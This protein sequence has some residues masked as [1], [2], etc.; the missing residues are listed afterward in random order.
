MSP[1]LEVVEDELNVLRVNALQ[2]GRQ[3]T[4]FFCPIPPTWIWL[5]RR[6]THLST[7]QALEVPTRIL[8][9]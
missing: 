1:T 3:A 5:P 7:F 4:T 9:V 8:R 2:F 6:D